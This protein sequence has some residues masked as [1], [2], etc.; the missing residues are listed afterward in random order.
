MRPLCQHIRL[1]GL[2]AEK[3]L[4]RLQQ[5]GYTLYDIRRIDL[6]TIELGFPV[7]AS[8]TILSFL[9]ERGFTCTPLPARSTLKQL[10]FLK[11]RTPLL[12]FFCCTLLLLSFSMRY[13]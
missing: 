1:Q 6:R 7:A 11:S 13:V 10:L 9:Q 4:T 12:I 3:Q 2:G 8:S 5:M